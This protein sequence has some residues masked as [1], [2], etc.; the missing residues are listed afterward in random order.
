MY[1]FMIYFTAK[2][3]ASSNVNVSAMA[4]KESSQWRKSIVLSIY[5]VSVLIFNSFNLPLNCNKC[6]HFIFLWSSLY[7]ADLGPS[8]LLLPPPVCWS[9]NHPQRVREWQL[10]NTTSSH[11]G[12]TVFVLFQ[13]KLARCHLLT[14]KA[15]RNSAHSLTRTPAVSC[16]SRASPW[17][18]IIHV[19]QSS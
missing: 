2:L 1:I 3:A 5:I 9:G 6:K 14:M 19:L 4:E 18:N 15:T 11:P 17:V 8:L 7:T 10:V 12:G 13:M 16:R